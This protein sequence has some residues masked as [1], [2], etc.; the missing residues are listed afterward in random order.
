MRSWF[1]SIH[2]HLHLPLLGTDDHGLLAHPPHHVEGTARLPSQRQFQ[3]IVLNAA[4]DDLAQFLGNG[5]EAVGRT[6]PLQGL[7]RPLVVVVLYPQPYPLAGGLEAVKLCSHQKLLPNRLPEPFDLPQ[8]H[9]MMGPAFDV[10]DP[11]LA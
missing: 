1:L 5:K 3:H 8:S 2:K 6:Q 4:L 7:V 11:I 9:G 10:M